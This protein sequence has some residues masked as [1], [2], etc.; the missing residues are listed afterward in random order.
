MTREKGGLERRTRTFKQGKRSVRV[1]AADR[2][3]KN[4]RNE[5]DAIRIAR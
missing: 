3:K 2:E 1:A 5:L 4:N